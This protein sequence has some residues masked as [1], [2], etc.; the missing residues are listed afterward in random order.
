LILFHYIIAYDVLGASEVK[1]GDLGFLD[2]EYDDV[3]VIKALF[4]NFKVM[5]YLRKKYTLNLDYLIVD[6]FSNFII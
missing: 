5:D 3:Y 1:L 2:C 6:G 4:G